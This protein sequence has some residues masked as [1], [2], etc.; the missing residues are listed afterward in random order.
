MAEHRATIEWQRGDRDFSYAAYSRDHTWQF[1]EIRVDASAAPAF[2]GTP[3]RV[4]PEEAFVAALSS[5]H[6]LT[7]LALASRDGIVVD[8]YEDDAV[9][10][11][12]RNGDGRL[13]I[14]RVVLRPR[15][16][17]AAARGQ[18][19]VCHLHVRI[20]RTPQRR[21][22]LSPCHRREPAMAS[23]RVRI[24]CRRRD[25]AEDTLHFRCVRVGVL[26]AAAGRC[27]AGDRGTRRTS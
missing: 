24:H 13:A 17:F 5:C 4:D 6:M 25:L 9:G 27:I 21:C 8:A 11:L 2:R 12:E 26:L 1:G 15:A 18:H 3:G 7:F 19:C 14:T 23:D 16:T 10:Y 22:S 20:D